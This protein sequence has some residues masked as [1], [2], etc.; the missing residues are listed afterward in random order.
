MEG[1]NCQNPKVIVAELDWGSVTQKQLL[2]LRADVVIAAGTTHTH[3]EQG[4]AGLS[5]P[6]SHW[7]NNRIKKKQLET[8]FGLVCVQTQ[9]EFYKKI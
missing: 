8:F 5:N 2:G 4:W 6:G 1:D 9:R 3:G 7:R